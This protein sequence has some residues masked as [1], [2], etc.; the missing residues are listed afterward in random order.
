MFNR[1]FMDLVRHQLI[2]VLAAQAKEA[3][4]AASGQVP[5]PPLRYG[6]EDVIAFVDLQNL[7]YFLRDNCR[8][9]PQR[10]H[11]P[12][13]LHDFAG[14]HGMRLTEIQIFTGIHD[15]KRDPHNHESM[16]KRLH[17]L[18]KCGCRVTALPLSY[19]VDRETQ[20]VRPQEK[21]V[22][23]RIAS[24][25]LRAV[26]DGLGKAIVI[27][28][29]KDI[30]QAVVVATEMAAERGRDF[31]AY[32]PQLAGAEWEHSGKCGMYGLFGTERL[33]LSVD[34]ARRHTRPERPRYDA[35]TPSPSEPTTE[36][37]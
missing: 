18:R 6:P 31:K 23:V 14:T 37:A 11:I 32:S 29:D 36:S 13:L 2:K 27:S 35:S 24:E 22:D 34:L 28:Q 25:L 17:W 5:S 3:K 26:N 12:D 7:F 21:G 1:R 19:H 4:A 30:A 10:V 15:P 8:V 9:A 20:Q 33:Q 16:S